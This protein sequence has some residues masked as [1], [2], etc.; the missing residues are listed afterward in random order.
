MLRVTGLWMGTIAIIVGVLIIALPGLLRWV[1]GI[2][3]IVMGVMAV[4]P[5]LR[6]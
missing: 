1:L 2:A 3:L 6:R 4:V 5:A